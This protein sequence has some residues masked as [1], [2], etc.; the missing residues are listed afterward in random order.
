MYLCDD[1]TYTMTVNE[2]KTAI[3]RIIKALDQRALKEAFDLLH[4]L[5]GQAH[6]FQFEGELDELQ[7]TYKQMLHYYLA[8]TNDPMRQKIFTKLMASTYEITDKIAQKAFSVEA[9]EMYYSIRRTLS[10]HPE[11]IAQL[12]DTVRSAYD[13]Q[14]I[15]HAESLMTRLFKAVWTSVFLSDDDMNSLKQSLLADES[16]SG[17]PDISGNMTLVNCQIVSALLLGLQVFFDRRKMLLLIDAAGSHNEEVKIR[18]FIGILITLY[19]YNQR[20][21]YYPELKYRIDLLS[22]QADF[23]KIISFVILRF[24]LSRDTEKITNLMKDELLPEMMKM[25]SKINPLSTSKTDTPEFLDFEMN[26]EWIENFEKSPLGKKI[27]QFSKLQEEGADVMLFSF[28]NLKH[29]PFFNELSNWFL[30]FSKDV[31]FLSEGN[32]VIKSLDLM[33]Q[34]GMMCNSDLYSFFFSMKSI[35]DEGRGPMIEKLEGQLIEWKQQKKT[36]LHT[37]HDK[38]ERLIGHYIQDLYRFYKLFPRRKEFQ[39]IFNQTFDFHNLPFVQRY[40]SD[41]NDLLYIAEYYMRKDYFED[42][43]TIYNRLSDSFETDEMLFQKKGYCRQMTGDYQGA[44]DEYEKAEL[45]NPASKWLL[46]RMAQCHRAAKKPETALSYY[47]R[48][49]KTE[50]ENITVLLNIGSCYLEMKKYAEALHYFFKADYLGHD[51][52]KAW[53]PIAWCSFLMGKY[54]QARNYYQL[55]LSS[56]PDYQDYTNAGHTEWALHQLHN[57][58]DYYVKSVENGGSGENRRLDFEAFR[59][60]FVKDIPELIAAGIDAD[61]IPFMLDKV[62]YSL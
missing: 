31:S 44:L 23:N 45:I 54:E 24:I 58:L 13:I 12:T 5:I 6:V 38:T 48:L 8:G 62:R 30:P 3:G 39:D 47:F 28:V 32:I 60:E 17:E 4:Q 61:E 15:T 35:H 1:L 14:N 19:R 36:E 55:I 49:E 50:P 34:V 53:R 52:G 29:F 9:P 16:S 26:P 20:I 22:E 57:A 51:S 10:V 40:F 43:L 21:D 25:N 37:R 2:I 27:E 7:E 59:K 18:A 56:N 11:N 41:K 46:R 42:A 33:T